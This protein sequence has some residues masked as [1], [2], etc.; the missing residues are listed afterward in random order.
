MLAHYDV[1]THGHQDAPPSGLLPPAAAPLPRF[2]APLAPAP[3]PTPTHGSGRAGSLRALAEPQYAIHVSFRVREEKKLARGQWRVQRND[4]WEVAAQGAVD[5]C[6]ALRAFRV[7]RTLSVQRALCVRD[8][9][10]RLQQLLRPLRRLNL[11]WV[12]WFANQRCRWI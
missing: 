6:V 1:L 12:R 11:R 9:G 2:S 4:A 10:K 5:H 8:E 3:A 7:G